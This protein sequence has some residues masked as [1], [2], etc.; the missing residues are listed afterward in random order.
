MKPC[1]TCLNVKDLNE[2]QLDKRTDWRC[3]ECKA[4]TL[5]VR[6]A[7]KAANRAAGLCYCGKDPRTGFKTCEEHQS[8]GRNRYGRL[9]SNKAWVSARSQKYRAAGLELKLAAF[10][11]YGGR[12][13]VC[14]QET[15]LEFLTIDHIVPRSAAKQRRTREG[16][17]DGE[18]VKSFRERSGRNSKGQ[19]LYRWM[20]AEGYPEGFR[21]LCVNCNFAR[22]QHG[23]CPHEAERLTQP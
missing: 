9:K 16:V 20:K 7:K 6:K 17:R 21:V 15:H 14:C 8:D 23:I 4:C 22:G 3:P 5:K 13:C 11:A 10:D 19:D 1:K 2:F 18:G 12:V